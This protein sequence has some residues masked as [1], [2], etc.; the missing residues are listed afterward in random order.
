[1]S[2]Q[3]RVIT[4]TGVYHTMIRGVNRQIIFEESS[5]YLHFLDLAK[6]FKEDCGIDVLAYCLMDNH[7]HFV[8]KDNTNTLSLFFK[9]LNTVYAMYYN[10]K[11]DHTG[12]LFQGRFRSE[13]IKTDAQLMQTIRYVHCNP[14]KAGIC[15][16]P[17]EYRF[18]SFRDYT[19]D[20]K[21]TIC[22]TTL[23][24]SIAGGT[25][26]FIRFNMETSDYKCMDDHPGRRRVSDAE[27]ESIVK[28]MSEIPASIFFQSLDKDSRDTLIAE[29]KNKGL[30]HTQIS[31]LTGL[32]KGIVA[33]ARAEDNFK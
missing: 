30:S 33:R 23:A 15:K 28:E 1:M 31:R 22:E 32:S 5:D 16:T 25:D 12:H 7:A 13:V 27:A 19:A 21:N 4:D 24:A 11:Y 26:S 18:S 8:L 2:R 14:I 29:L 20:A 3:A 6:R 10:E 9:K 17:E